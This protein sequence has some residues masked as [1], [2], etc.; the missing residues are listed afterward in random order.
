M[1]QPIWQPSGPA[2]FADVANVWL[3]PGQLSERIAWSRLIARL[4]GQKLEP[5]DFLQAALGDAASPE[6]RRII[7]QAPSRIHGVTMVL[8]SAEFNRR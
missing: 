5:S 8:A 6:T 7:S 3:T 1:G 4:L 2:G